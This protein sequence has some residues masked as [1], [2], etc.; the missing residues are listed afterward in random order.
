MSEF[1]QTLNFESNPITVY[2]IDGQP[3]FLLSEIAA[4]LGLKN[5]S[6]NIRESKALERGVDYD[7]F[8]ANWLGNPANSLINVNQKFVQNPITAGEP[9]S[10][11]PRGDVLVLY[12][13]GL[14]LFI[15]RSNKPV[16]APFTR[17]VIREAIPKAL[18][19]ANLDEGIEYQPKEVLTLMALETKGSEFAR[20]ELERL[21]LAPSNKQLA[22]PGGQD[23]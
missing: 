17:W 7:L 2:L 3:A 10:N 23:A 1:I 4:V 12:P 19:Q 14:F 18:F 21:G 11:A 5:P 9:G 15:I 16:A 20:A 6:K 8:P 13:S 22:L